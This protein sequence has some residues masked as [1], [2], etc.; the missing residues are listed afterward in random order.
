MKDIYQAFDD[1]FKNLIRVNELGFRNCFNTASDLSKIAI[2]LDFK[3]GL[4][5]AGVLKEVFAQIGPLLDTYDVPESRVRQLNY[6]IEQ[7]VTALSEVYK[8]DNAKT[9][10]VLAMLAFTAARFHVECHTVFSHLVRTERMV[11][12][13]ES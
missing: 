2:H 5:V 13:G 4:L 1:G 11:S 3:Q 8:D 7:N 6:E 10:E 9:F 12:R